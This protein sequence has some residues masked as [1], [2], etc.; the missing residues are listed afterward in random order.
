MHFYYELIAPFVSDSRETCFA[1]AF[2]RLFA[3]R[4]V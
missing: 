1:L 3:K 4:D 2:L